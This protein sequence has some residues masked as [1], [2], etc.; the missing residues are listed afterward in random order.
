MKNVFFYDTIIGKLAI[1]DNEKEITNIE[2]AE[3]E[4]DEDYNICETE[5]IKNAS[6]QLHEYFDGKRREFNL[7][8]R[9]D[10]TDFQNK[11]WRV[12]CEIPYGETRSYKQIAERVG[13]PNGSRAVGGANN[14]NPIMVVV[15]CHRVVGSNGSLVGYASGLHIKEVLLSIERGSICLPHM[16][17][18]PLDKRY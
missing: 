12:L 13:K 10:G 9:P 6:I 11:V 14:K 16:H 8:L 7:P 2:I 15:P 1:V 18:I 3:D 17:I 4:Y 5:L